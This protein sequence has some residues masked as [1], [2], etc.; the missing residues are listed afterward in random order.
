MAEQTNLNLIDARVKTGFIGHGYFHSNP[1]VSSDLIL[2]LRDDL[3]PGVE[4]GRPLKKQAT[5]F[6][7]IHPGYPHF[8][9]DV[10]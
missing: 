10:H 3:D 6:W 7:E 8:D 9:H 1:A 2:I 5:N 4:N